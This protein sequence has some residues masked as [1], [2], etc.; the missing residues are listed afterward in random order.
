[1]E[2]GHIKFQNT[3]KCYQKGT[4]GRYEKYLNRASIKEQYS[5]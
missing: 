4:G 5:Q 3:I 1:M 2:E